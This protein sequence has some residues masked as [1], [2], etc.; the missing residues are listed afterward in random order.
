MTEPEPENEDAIES[1]LSRVRP[2]MFVPPMDDE[3]KR[4]LLEHLPILSEVCEL[5]GDVKALLDE[6]LIVVV[7]GKPELTAAGRKLLEIL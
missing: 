5:T 6:R 1:V 3:R 4:F 2:P 7:D